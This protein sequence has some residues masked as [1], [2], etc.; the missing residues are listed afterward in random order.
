M[1]KSCEILSQVQNPFTNQEIQKLIEQY[2]QSNCDIDKFYHNVNHLGALVESPSLMKLRGDLVKDNTRCLNSNSSWTIVS[3]DKSFLEIPYALEER[4]PIYRIYINVKG[5]DKVQFIQS[6]VEGC[7][8]NS[9]R[10]KFKFSNSDGRNDEVIVLSSREEL[11]QNME[12]VEKIIQGMNLGLPPELVGVYNQKIG[13]GE[14]YIQ[15]P[16]YSFTQSRLGMVPLAIQKYLL[17]HYSEFSEYC[18]DSDREVLTAVQDIFSEE[19]S[20]FS[21][22]LDELSE[23]DDERYKVEQDL[24]AYKNNVPS[25]DLMH[26]YDAVCKY[27]PDSIQKYM[28]EHSDTA[29]PEIIENFRICC[30]IYGISENGLYS[31]STEN[32]LKKELLALLSS[33]EKELSSLEAERS[34]ISETEQLTTSQISKSNNQIGE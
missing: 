24:A 32:M 21:E 14:E 31:R 29:F 9:R 30:S 15:S 12:L 17:D 1:E 3:S 27:F 6:Y 7:E 18:S 23:E 19:V 22:E 13:I 4:T 11:V 2:I 33:K 5:E 26:M 34:L 25:G 16:I 20:Y 10:Y 8:S 28:A